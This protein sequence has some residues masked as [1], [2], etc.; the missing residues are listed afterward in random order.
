[1]I[2]NAF[3]LQQHTTLTIGSVG[4]GC[5]CLKYTVTPWFETWYHD[6]DNVRPHTARVSQDCLRIIAILPWPTQPPDL[7][8]IEQI[9]DHLGTR[10]GPPTNLNELQ[11]MLQQIWNEISQDMQNLHASMPD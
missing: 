7:S 9:R 10:V 4:I 2:R 8:P 11:A 6:S 5:H 3:A 1:M